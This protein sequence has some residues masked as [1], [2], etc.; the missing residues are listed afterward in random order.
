MKL[1][2]WGGRS[3]FEYT[4]SVATGTEIAYGKSRKVTVTKQQYASLRKHF[5]KRVVPV[6]T[7][8]TDMPEDSIG[9]W[10]RDNVKEAAIAT[11]VAAILL[12]EGYAE[13]VGKH[14]IKILR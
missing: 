6:G 5:L 9:E 13:R 14:D 7:S 4:G 2:T 11:Y 12:S 3:S 1:S 8:R 10:L